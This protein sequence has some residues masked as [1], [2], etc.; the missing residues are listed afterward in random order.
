MNVGENLIL[1]Q[2]KNQIVFKIEKILGEGA[3]CTVY[4]V[5][6]K[7]D[8]K[9]VH[10]GVLKE[11]NPKDKEVDREKY[12]EKF[13]KSYE[14]QLSF[15]S[16]YDEKMNITSNAEGLYEG[17]NTIYIL[18]SCDNGVSY[19]EVK[20]E[21]LKDILK[22]SLAVTKALSAYHRAGYLHLDIKPNNILVIPETKE[23]VKLFDFDS[24]VKKEELKDFRLSYS[25]NWSAPELIDK[26]RNYLICEAT[27]IYSI[28]AMV[29]NKIFNEY[30][31]SK[32]RRAFSRYDYNKE[33][34]LFKNMSPKI[35]KLLTN[36][37]RKTL[38]ATV[39]NRYQNAEEVEKALIELIEIASGK[40]PFLN[41][42]V[43]STSPKAL[44]REDELIE[45]DKALDKNNFV[46][47]YGMGGI[48][49]S[50]LAKMYA[51]KY[52][53]KYHT[54][55]FVQ[56]TE[57]IEDSILSMSFSNINEKDY[58]EDGELDLESLYV[59][60]L[61]IIKNL[62]EGSLIIVDNFNVSYDKNIG[63][64]LSF[65]K[66]KHKVIF[67]TRNTNEDYEDKYIN[68]KALKEKECMKLFYDFYSSGV[69]KEEGAVR[70]L[71]SLVD[72]N[73]LL[74]KLIALNCQKQR[75]K[76]RDFY[77]KLENCEL[78]TVK[79]KI[80]HTSDYIKEE[81]NNKRIYEHLCAIF[82]ISDLSV[83]EK[84]ILRNLS[85]VGKSKI[86]TVAFGEWYG[87]E[88]YDFINSLI[89]KGWIEWDRKN[90]MISLHH[91]ISDLSY[92][93][94]KPTGENCEEFIISITKYITKKD[95]KTYYSKRRALSFGEIIA[96]RLD[97]E[98]EVT[99]EFFESLGSKLGE[100]KA[101]KY[102]L[103]SIDIYKKIYG[104]G[105]LKEGEV[106]FKLANIQ[107]NIVF[108]EEESEINKAWLRIQQYYKKYIDIIKNHFKN[109]PE[110]LAEGYI[111]LAQ[112][113]EE[114]NINAIFFDV[115]EK[116]VWNEAEKYYLEALKIIEKNFDEDSKEAK[117]IY[118]LLN[119]FYSNM[120]NENAN[121]EKAAF[122]ESKLNKE[123][124]TKA[125]L[126]YNVAQE[127]R[128]DNDL[129]KAIGFLTQALKEGDE[130]YTPNFILKELSEVF[131]KKGDYDKALESALK[132]IKNSESIELDNYD[133]LSSYLQIGKI[134]NI[135][136]NFNKAKAYLERVV[137]FGE[138][139]IE[140]D[141]EE[142]E[143]TFC[144]E[145]TI[146]AYIELGKCNEES[147][148][149]YCLKA[150]DIY[151]K[152][153]E[154]LDSLY[155][156]EL[157]V[158]LAELYSNDYI[159]AKDY[160]IK[161]A[162]YVKNSYNDL[163]GDL[164]L[165]IYF[166]ALEVIKKILPSD[167]I[168][169]SSSSSKITQDNLSSK[170]NGFSLEE[171]DKEL[172]DIYLKIGDI[173]KEEKFDDKESLY[174]YLKAF[175]CLKKYIGKYSYEKAILEHKIGMA[176][177]ILDDKEKGDLYLKKCNYKLIAET[178]EK[179]TNNIAEKIEAYIEAGGNYNLIDDY[180]NGIYCY[181]KAIKM[182]KENL[183]EDEYK[184]ST[185]YYI[186]RLNLLADLYKS[187]KE[188]E[189][190]KRCYLEQLELCKGSEEEDLD[191]LIGLYK[192]LSYVYRKI[193]DEKEAEKY[194][195]EINKINEDVIKF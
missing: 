24:V 179:S 61:N 120:M 68:L 33:D 121:Y 173:F 146:K 7:E 47:I 124:V 63:D 69:V 17:N 162:E 64:I 27:D 56:Y 99:A 174:Y 39:K 21:S 142:L 87:L 147:K 89:E 144:A 185:K 32:D 71:L 170:Y 126:L 151:N 136:K 132:I 143:E 131:E 35:F 67:T 114:I 119:N 175:E 177:S 86:S 172:S 51:S 161:A 109:E 164:A 182:I 106:Y 187:I 74:I 148:L 104:E 94:L 91:I 156:K 118:N 14:I 189:N 49:K 112:A 101:Q 78:S 129:D 1:K 53:E 82:N 65:G 127:A 31:T 81:D 133:F 103:K 13:L 186:S 105:S 169:D 155:V 92:E 6:Y 96:K 2:G 93:E 95:W 137:G 72:Y 41:D 20:N 37:F 84:D 168:N 54:I 160:Y 183:N 45:I 166:K 12:K 180:K 46:F 122:Y 23:L 48:G 36:F 25:P 115:E 157:F 192:D 62:D 77:K 15:R 165:E 44:G 159:K 42:I 152:Y 50:E 111:K 163:E 55:Q 34:K 141:K 98:N 130:V 97:G 30:P 135:Q 139:I 195:E 18:M 10:S 76:L 134:Y 181:E 113:Y 153:E 59:N 116:F 188:Y 58:Y 16:D 191:E 154:K 73:T 145:C 190:A 8:D 108:Y 79:G 102:L 110:K 70:E 9:Y 167:E 117:R 150:L 193:G 128:Y 149:S 85:L 158:T 66:N 3:G 176:Y 26:S 140:N 100:E 184:T 138:K 90:D 88:D 5:K 171:K 19:D 38:Q 29:F 4:Y 75:I 123:Y 40:E 52:R 125:E 194:E 80:R 178:Q 83:E 57:G 43:W 28:G 22:T 11:F 60:K 107:K